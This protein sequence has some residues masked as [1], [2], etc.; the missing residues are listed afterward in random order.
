A[1]APDCDEAIA[2]IVPTDAYPTGT[3]FS[4]GTC[5]LIYRSGNSGFQ[6]IPGSALLDAIGDLYKRCPRHR[7]GVVARGSVGTGN[8]E[9]CHV[10]MNFRTDPGLEFPCPPC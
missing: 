5:Y 9:R 7:D 3:E 4:Y 2:R 8:C 10:T 6:W 1:K